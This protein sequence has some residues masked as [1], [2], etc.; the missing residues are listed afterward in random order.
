MRRESFLEPAFYFYRFYYMKKVGLLFF[1]LAT[2][3]ASAFAGDAFYLIKDGKLQNGVKFD[4]FESEDKT[5]NELV[6]GDGY[7][8]IKHNGGFSSALDTR[9]TGMDGLHVAT[10]SLIIEYMV[11][12]KDIRHNVSETTPE[13]MD[14]ATIIIECLADENSGFIGG[15]GLAELKGGEYVSRNLI[16]RTFIDGKKP[17]CEKEWQT[18]KEYTYALRD[19]E[20]K[21][22]LIS[23]KREVVASTQTTLK[24]KNLYFETDADNYPIYGCQFDGEVCYRDDNLKSIDDTLHFPNGIGMEWDR[25]NKEI[26]NK[27]AKILLIWD[28]SSDDG[29]SSAAVVWYDGSGIPMCQMYSA[30][31]IYSP[32]FILANNPKVGETGEYSIWTDEIALPEE[33]IQE[34]KIKIECFV[35]KYADDENYTLVGNVDGINQDELLPIQVKFDT[36]ESFDAFKD[37]IIYGIWTKEVG[38]VEIPNN[39]KSVVIEFK[40]NPVVSYLVDKLLISY[41]GKVGVA[42]I[43]GESKTLSVYPNPV[44]EAIEFAGIEDI[45]S[46]EIVSLNGAVNAC[47]VV[48]NKVNVSNLA[49]GEYVI[50]V[51]KNITGKFIK[52]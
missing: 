15:E 46:V 42:T 7:A 33:A 24:I 5:N 25:T 40:Q 27:V 51:N 37:S 3:C 39:A 11:D 48:N 35:K 22:V 14:K 30:L 23:Y 17:G 8:T 6:E 13:K 26:H 52:K 28:K 45:Q 31:P 2:C 44:S 16:S 4:P 32:V 49:A 10:K 50:I 18:F 29:D 19:K 9:L 20:V 12:E 34:G 36:G 43:N 41:K 47:K 1:A 38:E 21:S